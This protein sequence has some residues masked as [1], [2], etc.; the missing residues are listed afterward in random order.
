M[1]N[2]EVL[3]N[4][5]KKCLKL[6]VL[7]TG[8]AESACNQA[9]KSVDIDAMTWVEVRQAIDDGYATVIVPSGGIEENGP[10]MVLGK[11]DQIVRWTA[12]EIARLV[13]HTL[14]TPVISFVPE[15]DYGPGSPII[16]FPGTIGVSEE[17]FSAVLEGVARS[18]KASGFK[19]ICFIADHGGSVAVQSQVAARL[20]REWAS[21]GVRIFDVSDYYG[22]IETQNKYLEDQGEASA[23]IGDHAGIAD[24]SELMAVN[25]KGVDLSKIDHRLPF[26][27]TGA[28][29]DPTRATVERGKALLAIKIESA[30]RQI[31]LILRSTPRASPAQIP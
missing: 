2:I 22:A 9:T 18:L 29:G 23:S 28:S 16:Q 6:L 4:K 27:L 14:V 17:A 11:H 15:G 1:T 8:F 24:T 25:P 31:N 26:A 3:M 21:D 12:R 5:A 7:L 10:H 19:N 30:V 13:G 20:Q